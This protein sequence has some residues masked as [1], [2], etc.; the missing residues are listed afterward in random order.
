MEQHET[1]RPEMLHWENPSDEALIRQYSVADRSRPLVRANFISSLDGAA[2][3]DG[4]AGGLGNEDDQNLLR[5]MR[6]LS[7][8]VVVGAGTLRVEGYGSL[9]LTSEQCAWRVR[10]SL[11]E[12][13]TLAVVSAS[14]NLDPNSRAFTQAP[15]RPIIFTV[16]S[17]A[18]ERRRALA[19]VADVVSC[20]SDRF[21]P[22]SM[23]T[24]L[25]SRGMIHVL[26]EG[27]PH[28]F[29]TL[30]DADCVDELCLTLSPVIEN[31]PSLR[32]TAGHPQAPFQMRLAHVIAVG[33]LLMLRYTRRGS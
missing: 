14:L 17:A 22:R 11:P 32:I 2:T 25:A 8:V 23:L 7:D 3:Q 21:E 24:Q 20:G 28:L 16:D 15:V 31:G 30:L 13:P 26:C 29:S 1:R 4:H 33:D 12:H 19:A 18:L 5:V 10:T 27:G 9:G 6:V